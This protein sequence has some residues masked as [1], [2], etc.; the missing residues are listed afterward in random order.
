MRILCEIDEAGFFIREHHI[1]P[2]GSFDATWLDIEPPTGPGYF[3]FNGTGWEVSE[4]PPPT[5]PEPYIPNRVSKIDFARLFRGVQEDQIN[6]WEKICKS[7]TPEDYDDPANSLTLTVER[8]LKSFER[9][10]E[11]IELNHPETAQA[12]QLLAFVGVF[13][14]D[15]AYAAQEVTRILQG[16]FPS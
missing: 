12:L 7:I 11:Y 9:P 8:V 2:F 3:K 4:T 13:G 14:S 1:A 10:L 6:K 15:E 5:P 16:E